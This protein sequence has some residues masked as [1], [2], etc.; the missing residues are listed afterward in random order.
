MLRRILPLAAPLLLLASAPAS[1][2]QQTY[3]LRC[4]GKYGSDLTFHEAM[5]TS[6]VVELR[7]RASPRAAGADAS[8]LEPGT[9]SWIDRP[10]GDAEPRK[11]WFSAPALPYS[12]T[13]DP[14]LAERQPSRGTIPLYLYDESR[15]WSF[16][17]YNT[18]RGHLQA[19]EHRPWKD[20]RARIRSRVT[21]GVRVT[22]DVRAVPR[23]P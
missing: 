8:G 14:T 21:D 7:F 4:R 19:T 17:V 6:P 18:G 13:G 15:Y 20:P 9:C 16:W 12:D 22:P 10:L 5:L 1:G 11:V 3:E 23:E 2:R